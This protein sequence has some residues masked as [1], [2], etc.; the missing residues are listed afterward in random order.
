[1]PRYKVTLELAVEV[2]PARDDAVI[3]E[4]GSIET[5]AIQMAE[6]YLR[7]DGAAYGDRVTE[8]VAKAEVTS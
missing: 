5:A 4:E 3:A 8:L 1:M 7:S 2:D 6:S